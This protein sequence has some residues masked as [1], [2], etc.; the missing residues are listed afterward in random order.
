MRKK[1]GLYEDEIAIVDVAR[2]E[3]QKNHKFLFQIFKQ[4]KKMNSSAKL[5]LIGEGSLEEKLKEEAELLDIDDSLV[6]VGNVSNVGEYLNAMDGFVFPSLFEGFGT[7]TIESQ[8]CGL[9]ILASDTIPPETKISEIQEFESLDNGPDIWAEHILNMISSNNRKDCREIVKN[10]GFD[11]ND[12][13][14]FL[15][16]FYI[17]V[18]KKIN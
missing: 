11:I 16:K 2:L 4:I 13:Y 8:C 14:S 3:P 10:A 15:Q 12:T 9:S 18:S 7:V 17:E 1:L 5:F 6:F